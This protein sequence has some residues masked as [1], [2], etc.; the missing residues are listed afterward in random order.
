MRVSKLTETYHRNQNG[1]EIRFC[2]QEK[3]YDVSPQ[4]NKYGFHLKEAG[5]SCWPRPLANL[6]LRR[7]DQ[8][9]VIWRSKDKHTLSFDSEEVYT[10]G[11]LLCPIGTAGRIAR[12]SSMPAGK[13]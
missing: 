9:S 13:K 2:K 3:G 10:G 5:L 1:L 8:S 6:K 12:D 7:E 4:A 11:D